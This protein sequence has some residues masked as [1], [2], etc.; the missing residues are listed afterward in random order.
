MCPIFCF[1]LL[2]KP[3]RKAHA[4]DNRY[5]STDVVG[6]NQRHTIK[7]TSSVFFSLFFVNSFF[8]AIPIL[9]LIFVFLLTPSL[10]QYF[11]YYFIF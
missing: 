1:L 6:T 7:G 8:C 11:I 3:K 9:Y 10:F 2:S 5:G 4:M